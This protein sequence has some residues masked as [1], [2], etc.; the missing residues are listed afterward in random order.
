M[1]DNNNEDGPNSRGLGFDLDKGFRLGDIE[2]LPR[3]STVVRDGERHSVEPRAME[4]LVC[5]AKRNGDTGTHQEF[6]DEVWRG[7][8]V[9]PENLTRAIFMVRQ[10]L[11]DTESERQFV[12]TIPTRGYRMITGVTPLAGAEMTA[13][14][15]RRGWA[16]AATAV[17]LVAA[18]VIF[19][20]LFPDNDLPLTTISVQCFDNLSDAPESEYF[21]EGLAEEIRAALSRVDGVHVVSRTSSQSLC[22]SGLPISEIGEQLGAGSVLEGSVRR[23]ND[24]V[25]IGVQLS[26]TRDDQ[27]LLS[28]NYD[29]V[30][31]D[32]FELQNR[33]A[34]DVAKQM[35]VTLAPGE[36]LVVAPTQDLDAYQ[37]YLRAHFQLRRRGVEPV[38]RAIDLFQEAIARDPGYGRAYQGLAEAFAVAPSYTGAE[39][40]PFI[41]M[42]LAALD[43]A[44]TLGGTDS[45]ADA[46][47]AFIHMHREEWESA[48]T[49]FQTA[50]AGEPDN[51]DLLQ[52]HSIFLAG[53]GYVDRALVAAEK[54]VTE[55]PLSPVA[56]Q[57]LGIMYVWHDDLEGAEQQFRIAIQELGLDRAANAR[58]MFPLMLRRGRFEEA[59]A[60]GEAVFATAGIPIDW[61]APWLDYMRDEGPAAPAL[62]ALSAA[63]DTG[64]L[65][66]LRYVGALYYLGDADALFAAVDRVLAAGRPLD[67]EIWF[68]Q[69]GRVLQGDPR[70]PALLQR[71]GIIGYWD[72]HGWPPGCRRIGDLIQCG[73]PPEAAA[74]VTAGD[75]PVS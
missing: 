51:S 25:K 8:V 24:Q 39:V 57:R 45:H 33:I 50:L 20:E 36:L 37:L 62:D 64:T 34:K 3:Q 19:L 5:L 73:Q 6:E 53:L 63:Y 49:G 21:A 61:I 71:I 17:V 74:Q 15:A 52:W 18:V 68:V 28:Q 44:E 66:D 56:H 32:I 38:Q 59:R 67:T 23:V 9:G 2:V 13:T 46:I 27:V 54:S 65:S 43:K 12:Q 11:G 29:G 41:E 1:T 14:P 26:K 4:V 48:R 22:E 55:D 72:A 58:T 69:E 16:Y 7:R 31:A 47:R 30:F 75:P 40:E 60:F 10:A 70:F 35:S 42:S